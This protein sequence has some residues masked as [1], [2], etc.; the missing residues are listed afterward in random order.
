MKYV[1]FSI[2]LSLCCAAGCSKPVE[3]PTAASTP[4]ESEKQA[5][6]NS[7]LE[8]VVG[9]LTG[10]TAA[11]KGREARTKLQAIASNE[12]SSLEEVMR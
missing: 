11:K 1:M 6:E 10:Q 9:G 5:T 7:A 3:L 8:T 12:Q 4:G 2:V